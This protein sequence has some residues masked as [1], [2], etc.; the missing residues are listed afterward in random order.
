MLRND[1][2]SPLSNPVTL[3]V[4]G[5]STAGIRVLNADNGGGGTSAADPAKFS[6]AAMVG[7]ETL[8]PGETSAPRTV[9]FA[10]PNGDLFRADVL[11]LAYAP[12]P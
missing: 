12:T 4:V 7:G 3:S 6:Y 11:V 8:L 10:D 1:G 2:T 5:V 9:R